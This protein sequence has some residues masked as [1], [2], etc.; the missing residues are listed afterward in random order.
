MKN[1]K[2]LFSKKIVSLLSALILLFISG[3]TAYFT[4]SSNNSTDDQD[5]YEVTHVSDGDTITVKDSKG[6]SFK[7]RYIGMDTPES[8]KPNTPVQCFALKASDYN[9]SLVNG[10]KVKM[11]KDVEDKDRYDRL[12]RYIYIDAD[13]DGKYD[14]MVNDKLVKEGYAKV[15]TFPPN[16]KYVE[17]FLASQ[18]SAQENNLGLWKDCNQTIS[19][20]TP[21]MT[22]MPTTN[23]SITAAVLGNNDCKIKGNI[24]SAGEKIYHMPG[25]RYYDT[26]IVEENKGEKYFCDENQAISEGFRKS[27]V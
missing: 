14:E 5:L 26:T 12:L 4:I 16:I 7:V 25:Q 15:A 23:I 6:E 20:V 17:K 2:H 21:T 1:F 13:N 3:I 8:V 19:T 10:K 24:N 11:E 27:K 18:K 9:K 22:L